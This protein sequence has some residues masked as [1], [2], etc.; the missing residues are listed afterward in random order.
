V[1]AAQDMGAAGSP[2]VVPEMAA[3]VAWGSSLD[4]DFGA[5]RETGM[6]AYESLPRN[7]HERMLSW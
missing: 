5:G 7:A 4:L 1:V 2:A 3:K 6:T